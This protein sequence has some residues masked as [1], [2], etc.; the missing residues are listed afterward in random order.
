M[1]VEIEA[2]IKVTDRSGLLERIRL[3]AAEPEAVLMERDLFFDTPDGSLRRS[4][5]GLR[6]RQ[7]CRLDAAGVAG[8]PQI[9]LTFKGPRQEGALK[10]R[11]EI[12]LLVQ[13]QEGPT[14]LLKGLG[15]LP[16]LEVSKRR[17]RWLLG[18]C[19]VE[20]DEVEGLG[21]FLEVEG[22]GAAAVEAALAML[23][24]Q[25]EPRITRSYVAMLAEKKSLP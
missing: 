6:I 1:G 20:F 25:D 10:T 8:V 5:R 4:D 21:E 15:Y 16:T 13:D 9:I 19:R 23:E 7:E 11:E 14:A 3:A 12:E 17:T 18:G 22:P 2:K 24:L